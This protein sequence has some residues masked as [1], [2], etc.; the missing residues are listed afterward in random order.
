[1]A[2]EQITDPATGSDW[3]VPPDEQEGLRRYVTTL[4]ERI[5]L[6]VAITVLTTAVSIAYVAL[7]T[8]TYEAEA[9]LLITPVSDPV[10]EG[11]GLIGASSDPTRD[12]QTASELVTTTSVAERVKKE[13]DFPGEAS[14]LLGSVVAEPVAQSNIVAV[15]AQDSDP[16]EAADLANAFAEQAV[17]NR[18]EQLHQQIERQLP[19]L[20]KIQKSNPTQANEAQL[21]EYERLLSGNDPTIRVETEA[22]PPT[23]PVSPRPLLSVAA[24]IFA[25]LALGITAAFAFQVLDPRLRREEQLR[26]LFRLPIIGRVPKESHGSSDTPLSPRII[27]PATAEA[28]RTL[29]GTVS[30]SNRRPGGKVLLVTGSSP[31]EGKTSTAINLAASLSATGRR[32]IL[33]EA[34]L[35]RPAISRALG[36]VPKRGVV[37][38]LIESVSLEDALMSGD[39]LGLPNLRLL[40]AENE[41]GWISELFSLP[42][43]SEMLE[44]ARNLADYVII[45]SPPLTDVVDALPLARN[46]DDVL[47]VVRPGTTR[48]S[49]LNQ[50][51]ELLAENGIRPMGFAVVG[52][53][54]Q[55]TD[56]AYYFDGGRVPTGS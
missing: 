38:V 42:T 49:K 54:R 52:A 19:G 47:L 23:A 31:S 39:T 10:L 36:I 40:L 55:G 21:A 3:L 35:R 45:D 13:T 11:L 25:G 14:A 9:T 27:S 43:A 24:G 29:R 32:V 33:I 53:P 46:V 50:L 4:R 44:D 2:V 37:G 7:A 51:G 8:K 26:H 22:Q 15:T 48:L 41:G 6:I 20:R 16:N 17:V 12:V 18:T 30:A 1:M 56:S 5:W 28:Y 34:D